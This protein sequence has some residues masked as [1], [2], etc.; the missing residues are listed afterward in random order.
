ML[1]KMLR[2]TVILL[3]FTLVFTSCE[4]N[5]PSAHSS[6]LRINL[7]GTFVPYFDSGINVRS[8][9][10]ETLIIRDLFIDIRRIEVA[11]IGP[12]PRGAEGRNLEEEWTALEFSGREFNILTLTNGRTRGIVEQWFPANRT[13]TRVRLVLGDNSRIVTPAYRVIPLAIPNE[14]RDGIIIDNV[15]TELRLNTISGIVIDISTAIFENRVNEELFIDPVVRAFDE[16]FGGTLRGTVA[17]V[18]ARSLVR[19]F[20][21]EEGFQLFSIPEQNGMF[22]FLGLSE[23]EWTIHIFPREEGFRDT[24]FTHIIDTERGRIN[25]LGRIP[26]RLVEIA[27]PPDD[28]EEENEDEEDSEEG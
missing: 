17:P 15:N 2:Y 19:I 18:E 16:T 7:T 28:D 8:S 22:T 6:K 3:I 12:A 13:I 1:S 10:N 24:T 4:D 5:D 27:P 14:I 20:R 25:E 9:E 26:L 21:E 11:T 23:D